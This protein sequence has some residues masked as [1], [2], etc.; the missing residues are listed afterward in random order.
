MKLKNP[1]LEEFEYVDIVAPWKNDKHATKDGVLKP[2]ANFTSF[3]EKDNSFL[4][5]WSWNP[6]TCKNETSSSTKEKEFL[7]FQRESY[8]T[9]KVFVFLH[10]LKFFNDH[11]SFYSW[12]TNDYSLVIGIQRNI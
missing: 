5:P 3:L 2:Q 10:C 6:N 9:Y 8:F 4:T 7:S 11:L 12:Y 1:T